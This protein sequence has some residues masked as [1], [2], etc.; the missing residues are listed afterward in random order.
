M[1]SESRC[2]KYAPQ[3]V[4]AKIAPFP[5]HFE[6]LLRHKGGFDAA[7]G[8]DSSASTEAASSYFNI[9]HPC[10]ERIKPLLFPIPIILF[11]WDISVS[12][13]AHPTLERC[14]QAEDKYLLNVH[15]NTPIDFAVVSR[16]QD[17]SSL[18][19]SY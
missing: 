11:A 14:L 7:E 4:M 15:I 6:T 18:M 19:A 2:L 17:L 3:E 16:Y 10:R 8:K 5:W 1:K 9:K 12:S 13:P